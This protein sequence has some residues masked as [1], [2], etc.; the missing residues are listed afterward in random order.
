MSYN[1]TNPNGQATSANSS[2]VVIAS[3][4]STVSTDHAKTAGTTTSVNNGTTDAGTQRVTLSSDSTGQVI[5]RGN[6][7]SGAADSGNPVKVG[8]RFNSAAPTLTD[9][10]RGD[11]QLDSSGNLKVTGSVG[12]TANSSVNVNQVAG[13]TVDTNSGNKSAGTQRVVLATDQPQLTNALKVDGSAVTQPV[14]G[15]VTANIGTSGSLALDATLTGGTQK[16]KLVDSGGTNVATV[17]AGGALKVDGSAATQPVSGTITANIGTSG[18]LALD[19]SVTGLQ[20]S[21]GSTTS[22]QKGNLVQG[23]VTTSAPTYT[24]AQTSPLS[25]TTGGALRVDNSANTQPVSGT[26]TANAGTGTFAANLT[27]AASGGWS[28]SSQTSLTTTATVSSAAGKFGGY[29]FIN[30]NSAPAYIQVFD[31]TSAVTLGTTTPTF[32][33]PLPANGTAANGVGANLEMANGIA[34]TN[35]IK[36]AATTTATG[37]STVSTGLTGFVLYK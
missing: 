2:P 18:S 10:Q 17:S 8:G 32:V 5:A 11:L 13:T 35:G 16:T 24:T 29:M 26:V 9:G 25:L 6:V 34:I 28:V 15:T 20:V 7:A 36:V 14:S 19:A 1:P 37:A 23:A 27:P 3:D 30:L 22:G 4:Q 31:T 33:I 12:V 21:Q